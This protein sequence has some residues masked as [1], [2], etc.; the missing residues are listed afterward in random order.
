MSSITHELLCYDP[1]FKGEFGDF[2]DDSVFSPE[3]R[4][5]YLSAYNNYLEKCFDIPET[6]EYAVDLSDVSEKLAQFGQKNGEFVKMKAYRRDMPRLYKN[7]NLFTEK[8]KVVDGKLVLKSAELPPN[9]CAEYCLKPNSELS[10]LCFKFKM[11]SEYSAVNHGAVRET[12]TVRTIEL[13]CKNEEIVKVCF[14][15]NGECYVKKPGFDPYHLGF[16]KI[17]EYKFD[18]WNS[19]IISFSEN[20]YSVEL[21][22]TVVSDLAYIQPKSPNTLFF[23][24]GMFH[25]GDWEIEPVSLKYQD[26]EITDFF[27]AEDENNTELEFIGEV[28]LPYAIG[29]NENANKQLVL[30]KEFTLPNTKFAELYFDSLDPGGE[31]YIDGKK[32]FSTDSFHH[33]T[34]DISNLDKEKSHELT[35]V[36]FPRA[37]EFLFSWHR[38]KDPYNGWFCGEIAI[39][40]YNEY[41]FSDLKIVTKSIDASEISAHFSGNVNNE[42][43]VE[44]YLEKIFG[45]VSPKTKIAQF[46][47]N[48]SFAETVKFKADVWDI[49][50]P[51]LYNVIF[52]AVNNEKV[53]EEETIETGFRKI[54]QKDGEVHLNNR[55]VDLK[56]ALLMQFLPPYNKTPETHI[57]PSDEQILWQEMMLQAMG[58][59]TLRIHI[60]GY[61][62]NDAR[63]AR[64]ADRL[65]IL[66]VWI[67]RYIDSIEGVQWQGKWRAKEAYLEQVK[68]R[69][70]HPSIIMW[71]GSNELRADNKQINDALNHFVPAV[72]S[73]DA[74]R[75]ICPV[76]HLYYAA[77]LYPTRGCEYLSEDCL[78][79]H[80][81]NPTEVSPYWDDALVVRS[82]HT[83]SLLC[84]YGTGWEKLRLQPWGEQEKLVNSKKHAYLVTEY[85]VI[86]RQN[87]NVREAREEYFNSF[88][89]EF[90]D[91]KPLGLDLE[92]SDWKISQAYQALCAYHCT[93]KLKLMNTDGFMWCCLM[94]GANDGGYLKPLI[95]NYGYKK[96]GFYTM[97]S[98]FQSVCA[99]V[100]GVNIKIGGNFAIKPVLFGEIGKTYDVVL[101]VTDKNGNILENYIYNDVVAKNR[102]MYLSDFVSKI[103]ET[104]FYGISLEVKEKENR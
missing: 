35:V 87:P 55:R 19:L 6:P 50:E 69:I 21:N 78:H 74:S 49:G 92:E 40:G 9:P 10:E 46:K 58:G 43:T 13:R 23:G 56:G 90:P 62:T 75:L 33:F 51:N 4:R 41:R 3:K 101:S 48:G 95:D 86:G 79:D 17:G 104:G 81:G 64:F 73:V 77:D 8:T 71:E 52:R 103:K 100:D 61:G 60:L 2:T 7:W 16:A 27:V 57:C 1:S 38:Q 30:Q 47:A 24:S 88:S 22:G 39:K 66:L 98:A 15:H 12:T 53:L 70:N 34:L 97:K 72:K 36:V 26:L 85:A 31:I 32:V 102:C 93:K 5:E 83:Y 94:G 25:F 20:C 42:C 37:P 80:N 14:Y 99:F 76:S 63:Y 28:E 59:N 54:E 45:G 67:T 29:C 68:K 65:G 18:E 89:Y 82:A 96:T 91:E 44:I 84:G 11:D